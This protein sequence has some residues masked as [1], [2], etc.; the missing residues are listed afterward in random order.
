MRQFSAVLLAA[1]VILMSGCSKVV[2]L[3]PVLGEG[4]GAYDPALVGVWQEPSGDDTFLVRWTGE[5]YTI[6]YSSKSQSMTFEARLW[7]ANGAKLLDVTATDDDPFRLAI[8]VPVRVWI[9][10]AQLRFAFLDSD[11]IRSLAAS[12]MAARVTE[13]RTLVLADSARVKT[14]LGEAGCDSRAYKD[15]QTVMKAQ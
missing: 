14:F 3:N 1:G 4:E 15:V 12:R 5:H 6:R 13:D 8:H 7:D 9:E 2:S 10:G 11:W